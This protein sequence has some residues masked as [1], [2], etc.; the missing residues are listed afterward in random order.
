MGDG[1]ADD[2]GAGAR[3]AGGGGLGGRVDAALGDEEGR[4]RQRAGEL[5][6]EGGIGGVGDRQPI[7]QATPLKPWLQYPPGFRARYCWCSGSA[8]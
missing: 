5:L 3:G 4:V 1:G 7:A 2:D 6:D 8:V